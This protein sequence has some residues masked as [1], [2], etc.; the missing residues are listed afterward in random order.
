M[1]IKQ[2]R[3]SL[4]AVLLDLIM[5]VK[6]GYDVMAEM[7]QNGLM[8]CIPVVV[9]TSD[10]ST[11]NEVRAFD[12]GAADIILKPFAVSYTHLDVYKRQVYD[13]ASLWK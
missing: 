1:L 10:E 12:L 5:P 2:Y 8:A 9:I 11:D 3:H 13:G 7:T 4:A 6:S